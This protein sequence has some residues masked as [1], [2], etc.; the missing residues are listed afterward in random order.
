MEVMQALLFS[1]F[2]GTKVYFWAI[3]IAI[4]VG[5]LCFDLGILHKEDKEISFLKM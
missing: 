5:L 2:L 3:F 1:D 4:V